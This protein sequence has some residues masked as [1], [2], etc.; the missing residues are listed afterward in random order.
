MDGCVSSLSDIKWVSSVE[1]LIRLSVGILGKWIPPTDIS[2]L[3]V[4]EAL[5]LDK[6]DR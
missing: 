2:C 6:L 1:R 3:N 5:K 4:K